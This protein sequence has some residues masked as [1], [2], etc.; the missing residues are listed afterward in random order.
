[1]RSFSLVLLSFLISSCAL[2]T[3]KGEWGKRAWYPV[4]WDK[5]KTAFKKNITSAHVWAPVA[6]AGVLNVMAWDNNLQNWINHER[7]IF[8]DQTEAENYSYTFNEILKYEMYLSIFITPSNDSENDLG[9]YALNKLKGGT[10]VNVASSA[11][12]QAHHILRKSTDRT[13]P[14]GHDNNSMP[15]GHATQSGA[16]RVLVTRN[17]EATDIQK[18][19]QLL[20]NTLNT[21]LSAGVMWARVEGDNHYPTDVLMGYALGSF[22]SGFIYDSLINL[23]PNHTFSLAPVKQGAEAR[24][25]I[26]F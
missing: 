14:S 9:N 2:F 7:I 24:Y 15:S 6:S 10:L 21:T 20:I 23:E 25:T 11:S 19:H 18:T 3:K 17:L 1:M 22:L 16:R 12:T 5:I 8:D 13:R 26:N 4:H